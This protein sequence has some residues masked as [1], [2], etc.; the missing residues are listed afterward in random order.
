MGKDITPSEA[1]SILAVHPETLRRYQEEGLISS[2]KT[3]G[4]HRR[5]DRDEIESFR[6][7]RVTSTRKGNQT[8][9][10]KLSGSEASRMRALEG[11]LA[12]KVLEEL[13]GLLNEV[14]IT[15]ARSDLDIFVD[16]EYT[17]RS[18]AYYKL[19][20]GYDFGYLV[21][22]FGHGIEYTPE[23]ESAVRKPVR[24]ADEIPG[25]IGS[26]RYA[27]NPVWRSLMACF[28]WICV[29]MTVVVFGIFLSSGETIIE[30]LLII[31]FSLVGLIPCALIWTVLGEDYYKKNDPA[32]KHKDDIEKY[33]KEN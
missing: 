21:C 19:N 14:N 17:N 27:W 16:L 11:D 6:D 8:I 3:P 28:P 5:Y 25:A 30:S 20:T 31:C 33:L 23:I 4:G 15:V 7:I 29:L 2:E 18:R 1:A 32:L 22:D 9:E 26:R 24:R 12:E 10:E 13:N